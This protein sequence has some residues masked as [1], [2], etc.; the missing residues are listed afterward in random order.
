MYLISSKTATGGQKH[1]K[2]FLIIAVLLALIGVLASK[3]TEASARLT[4]GHPIYVWNSNQ[5][6]LLD[7][8]YKEAWIL[9]HEILAATKA[10]T[11]TECVP[12]E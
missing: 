3:T 12:S 10:V 1:E 4:K 8:L 9:E 11:T 5:T 7:V 2:Q 6:V